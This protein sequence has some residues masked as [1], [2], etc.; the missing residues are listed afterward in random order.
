MA[1]VPY[2]SVPDVAPQS[3]GTGA[4]YGDVP[5]ANA[6]AFGGQIGSAE[7]QAGSQ[8]NQLAQKFADIY[9]ESTARD[10]TT[11]TANDMADAEMRF[12]QLKGNDAVAG[13]KPFQDEIAAIAK[14]NSDGLSLNAN[15]MYQRDAASLVNNATFRAGSHVGEQAEVAQKDSLNASL[16]TNVNQFAMNSTN[17][18]GASYLQKIQNDALSYAQHM[19]ITDPSVADQL[20][21][22]NYGEAYAAAIKTNLQSNPDA[23]QKLWDQAS[24]AVITKPDGS[25]VPYLDANHRAGIA[26]EMQGEFKRQAQSTLWDASSLAS[27][28]DPYNKDAVTAAMLRAGY[29]K[30]DVTA[31]ITHLDNVQSS[32]GASNARFDLNRTFENDAALAYAGKSPIGTYDPSV[33]QKVFSKEPDKAQD[34]LNKVNQLSQV[35]AFVGGMSTRTPVQN[36]AEL[37]KFSP[38]GMSIADSIHQ[39]ESGGKAN[40]TANGVSVGGWQVTPGTFAQYAKPGEDINNPKDN[41]AVGRRIIDDLSTKFNGDPERVAVGY[42]SGEGNV[43]PAGSA[44]P[45]ISDTHDKN[46]KS[47]SSYVSDVTGRMSGSQNFGEQSDLQAN[48][49]KAATDYYKKLNDDPAGVITGNDN[50]LNAMFQDAVQDTKN[51]QKMVSYVNDVAARQEALQVPEANRSVLP[52]GYAASITNG[53]IANPESAPDQLAKMATDYGNAWPSVYKSLVQQGGMPPAYQIVQQLGA[54]PNTDKYGT[55]FARYLGSDETKGK[56]DEVLMGGASTLKELNES[57][58]G[59]SDVKSLTAS[60]ARS[61]ASPDQVAGTVGSVQKLAMAIH[62]YDPSD[63]NPASTAIK[64]MTSKY[65]YLPD[66]GARVPIDRL[67]TI[68]SNAQVVLDN[69]ETKMSPA[70]FVPNTYANRQQYIDDVKSSPSWVTRGAENKVYLYDHFGRPVMGTDGKQ[71]GLGFDDPAM[72]NNNK[73]GKSVLYLVEHGDLTG[74]NMTTPPVKTGK[75]KSILDML[76]GQ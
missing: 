12:H 70:Q 26:S 23:A 13:L 74:G 71:I 59:N 47:V 76:G 63:S 72:P 38:Q 42:F 54:D 68:A 58:A 35:A 57:V 69:I 56:T 15:S 53:L 48:M 20:V 32:F 17:P 30:D 27:A 25:T 14:N 62:F 11:K 37:D 51:P 44:T 45:W 2:S 16:A 73:M 52:K 67:D 18:T 60:L 24:T 55:M 4:S 10:A 28:G 21:S 41:E 8:T 19:G 50:Q 33:V 65:A 49:Q 5:Q 7:Q 46:G 61:G 43:A 64:A 29:T 1:N 40:A 3:G 36:Q 75:G 39:Q 34:F 31:H 22:H 9:N 6:E 66:G